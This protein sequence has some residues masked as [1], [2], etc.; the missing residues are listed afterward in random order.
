MA[1]KKTISLNSGVSGEYIRVSAFRWDRATREASVIFA[2]YRDAATAAAGE[3]LVPI[4]AK[5][6]LDGEQ[7]DTHLG[8]AAPGNMLARIYAAA[9]Q[10][11][12]ISDHGAGIFSAA[13]DV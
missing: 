2:L 4:V 8:H 12:V 9:R 13:E 6:R 10:V 3:P 11:P 1:F 5:L 7:F